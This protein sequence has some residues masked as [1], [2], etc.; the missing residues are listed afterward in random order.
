MNIT[1]LYLGK[2]CL[3]HVHVH[4]YFVSHCSSGGVDFE[5]FFVAVFTSE[6][7]ISHFN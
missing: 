4:P 6:T 7:F 2:F 5:L 3:Q 1:H